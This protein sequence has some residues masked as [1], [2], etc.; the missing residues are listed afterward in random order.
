MAGSRAVTAASARISV[1][2]SGFS[3]VPTALT[4]ARRP[5]AQVTTTAG[6]GEKPPDRA[7]TAT[8][9]EPSASSMAA[10]NP[11]GSRS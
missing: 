4:N 3:G 9:G 11:S 5:S 7:E 8:T 2:V 6:P 10:R 1:G